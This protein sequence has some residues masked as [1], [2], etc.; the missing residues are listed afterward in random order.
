MREIKTG[1]FEKGHK[2]IGGF[3]KGSH[4]K[5]ESI[6]KV[7]ASLL[8]K[9]GSAARRWKGDDAGYVAKHMW[10]HKHFG[11]ANKCQQIGC[12]FKNP[13]RFE[14]SNISGKYLREQSDYVML[15]CSCHRRIDMKL[16][17]AN[18]ESSNLF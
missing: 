2:K 6:K 10:I 12:S 3:V 1:R 11:K 15:C 17:E 14:W 16:L 13:K 8:G 9:N 18:Y 5:P 4:H 7:S